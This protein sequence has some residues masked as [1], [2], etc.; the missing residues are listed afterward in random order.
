MQAASQGMIAEGA[1][2]DLTVVAPD[3][4]KIQTNVRLTESDMELFRE[5]QK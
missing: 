3:G 1:I 5:F 4:R 2:I